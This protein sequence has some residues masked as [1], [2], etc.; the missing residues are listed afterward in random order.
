MNYVKYPS[1]YCEFWKWSRTKNEY[2]IM[3]RVTGFYVRPRPSFLLSANYAC[4][5]LNRYT[6]ICVQYRS[7]QK[8]CS[9]KNFHI[10]ETVLTKN[11]KFMF[12]IITLGKWLL[13]K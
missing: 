12:E 9:F 6:C 10:I 11:S 2:F 3:I 13:C 4:C 8:V 1:F 5:M 7:L